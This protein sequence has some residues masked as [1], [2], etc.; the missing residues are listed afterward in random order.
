MEKIFLYTYPLSLLSLF[1]LIIYWSGFEEVLRALLLEEIKKFLAAPLLMKVSGKEAKENPKKEKIVEPNRKERKRGF[2][3]KLSKTQKIIIISVLIILASITS[4]A[5]IAIY[6]GL[7]GSF[8]LFIA[9][10][11][12]ILQIFTTLFTFVLNNL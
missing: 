3:S 1:V 11:S 4:S 2:L 5:A 10:V 7:N 8:V 12:S 6:F 9:L